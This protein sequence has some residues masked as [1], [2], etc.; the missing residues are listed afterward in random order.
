MRLQS[1]TT[2]CASPLYILFWFQLS[3]TPCIA[4][5][6]P[7]NPQDRRDHSCLCHTPL[8]LAIYPQLGSYFALGSFELKGCHSAFNSVPWVTPP[9]PLGATPLHLLQTG[10]SAF[11]QVIFDMFLYRSIFFFFFP[12]QNS[13]F[14]PV[15]F[16]AALG[17]EF[18]ASCMLGK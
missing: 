3:Q 7:G 8:A 4:F 6:W 2:L 10:V 1:G 5:H 9:Q 14:F 15:K 13:H 17:I 18:I 16:L 11:P 12:S